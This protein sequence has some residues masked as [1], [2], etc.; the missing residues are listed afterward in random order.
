MNKIKPCSNDRRKQEKLKTELWVILILL[1]ILDILLRIHFVYFC[2]TP[3]AIA[4][5]PRGSLGVFL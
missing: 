2:K 4:L 1:Q 5:Q 3:W